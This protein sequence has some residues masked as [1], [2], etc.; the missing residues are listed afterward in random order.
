MK[1]KAFYKIMAEGS[2]N[3]IMNLSKRYYSPWCVTEKCQEMAKKHPGTK[4]FVMK[5]VFYAKADITLD[6][7]KMRD[8]L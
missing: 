6:H 1:E 7:G 2:N 4:F 5:A 3:N 8:T